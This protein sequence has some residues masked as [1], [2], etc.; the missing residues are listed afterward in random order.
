M[1]RAV[2]V[3]LLCFQ[4]ATECYPQSNSVL[5][6]RVLEMEGDTVGAVDSLLHCCGYEVDFLALARREYG[7]TGK[8]WGI[9]RL[10]ERDSHPSCLFCGSDLSLT[11]LSL[12]LLSV[13]TAV[14]WSLS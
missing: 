1:N 4:V 14:M 10:S 9:Q 13:E 5:S 12:Y 2:L 3:Q 6:P 7:C 11:F 8:R